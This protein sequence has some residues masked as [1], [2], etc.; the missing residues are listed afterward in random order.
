[1]AYRRKTIRRLTPNARKLAHLANEL[2]SVHRRLKNLVVEVDRVEGH[3]DAHLKHQSM[4]A[5][6]AEDDPDE[7]LFPDEDPTEAVA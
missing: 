1:M 6:E 3:L 7:P 5:R 4:L 2:D